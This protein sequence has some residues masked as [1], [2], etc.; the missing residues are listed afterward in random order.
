MTVP[1]YIPKPLDEAIRRLYPH[2]DISIYVLDGQNADYAPG[3]D[4]D[5]D[6]WHDAIVVDH[7]PTLGPD[8]VTKFTLSPDGA[9]ECYPLDGRTMEQM[10][11]DLGVPVTLSG[12]VAGAAGMMAGLTDNRSE[13]TRS[14]DAAS[15]VALPISPA[16]VPSSRPAATR[17]YVVRWEVDEDAATPLEAARRVW[18]DFFNRLDAGPDDCCDFTVWPVDGS[19]PARS[20]DLSDPR[21]GSPDD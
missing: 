8:T 19:E 5:H 4:N 17:T 13:D 3:G 20:I 2:D 12:H 11:R 14:G 21:P 7:T 9:I 18:R 16:L 15:A 1:T 10:G 6:D